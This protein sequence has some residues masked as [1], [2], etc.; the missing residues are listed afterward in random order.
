[1]PSESMAGARSGARSRATCPD[2]QHTVCVQ[3]LDG[4]NVI[5]DPE[6]ITV[7]ITGNGGYAIKQIIGRRLHVESCA[8]LAGVTEKEKLR[9]EL[10]Q[11][12]A[13]R[14]HKARRTKGM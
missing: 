5:T 2:C 3:H 13:K 14:E 12:E 7:V 1:M 9:K 6:R 8:R 10:R 11:W 4:A